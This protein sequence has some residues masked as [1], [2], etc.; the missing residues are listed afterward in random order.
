MSVPVVIHELLPTVGLDSLPEQKRLDYESAY[1]A[2]FEKKRWAD[3]ASKLAAKS[4]IIAVPI[5]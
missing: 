5:P 1:E 4:Q 2:V 3:A